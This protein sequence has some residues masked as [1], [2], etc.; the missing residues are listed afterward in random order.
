VQQA[1]TAWSVAGIGAKQTN[2]LRNTPVY[3]TDLP[4]AY[5]GMSSPDGIWIDRDAA[6][7]GWFV[8]PT[9]SDNSEFVDHLSAGKLAATEGSPAYGKMDLLTIIEHEMGRPLGLQERPDAPGIMVMTFQPGVRELVVAADLRSVGAPPSLIGIIPK[10]AAVASASGLS[11]VDGSL[12]RLFVFSPSGVI[13][14][15]NHVLSQ[16]LP[17]ATFSLASNENALNAVLANLMSDSDFVNAASNLLTD[18]SD[19]LLS[20]GRLPNIYDLDEFWAMNGG[21]LWR[22][23]PPV[24]KEA[25]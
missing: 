1:T 13:S 5:V 12:A 20:H 15:E 18:L 7:H 3:I 21:D 17:A 25:I 2:V 6:G 11:V 14:T 19:N 16:G 10:P 4:G 23:N 24:S 8:D 22:D 9:P